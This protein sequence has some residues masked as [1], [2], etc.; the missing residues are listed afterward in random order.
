MKTCLI[1]TPILGK[2]MKMQCVERDGSSIAHGV[3][4]SQFH[5]GGF[6]TER[7][8]TKG[9]IQVIRNRLSI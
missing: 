2:V 5:A 3:I 1:D 8:I 7:I 4:P 6:L 9:K